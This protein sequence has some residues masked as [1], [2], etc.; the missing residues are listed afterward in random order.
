MANLRTARAL[1][2]SDALTKPRK[3]KATAHAHDTTRVRQQEDRREWG[4]GH[5]GEIESSASPRL[6]I[7][8]DKLIDICGMMAHVGHRYAGDDGAI[9]QV[10]Q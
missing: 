10:D 6:H 2:S 8:V 1:L 9:A 7:A 3:L 5:T 4:T